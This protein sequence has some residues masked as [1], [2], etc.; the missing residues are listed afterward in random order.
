M[1]LIFQ[2]DCLSGLRQIPD[3]TVNTCVTS[4]PYFGLRDYGHEGQIGLEP[5][6]DEFVAALVCVFREVRRVLRDDGT[7]WLNLGDSYSNAGTRQGDRGGG[8]SPGTNDH[9]MVGAGYR[10]RIEG[11][12]NTNHRHPVARCLCPPSRWLVFTARYH[13]AQAQPYARKRARPLHQGA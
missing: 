10:T 9:R 3:G 5:T 4:P 2:G 11:L 6:P 1:T 8:V 13:L 12:K 7:L